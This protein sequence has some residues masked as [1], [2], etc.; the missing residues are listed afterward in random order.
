MPTTLVTLLIGALTAQPSVQQ[1]PAGSI[2]GTVVD[3]VAGTSLPGVVIALQGSRR[4]VV[5]DREGA[6]V[7]EAV[8]PGRHTLYVSLVGYALARPG[9]DVHAGLVSHVTVPLAPGTGAYTETVTVV[10]DAVR[11]SAPSV[12]AAQVLTSGELLE[13]RGVL[14]DDPLRAVQ[15]LPS[16][17]TGDDFRSEFSV[18]GSDFSHLGL[19]ID[20]IPVPW[21]V[22]TVADR[23]AEG[24]ISMVNGTVLDSVSLLA[25]TY[26]QDRPGRTGAWVDLTIREG[27][28]A[29]TGF[30]GSLSASAASFLVEGPLGPRGSWLISTRQSYLQWLLDRFEHEGQ[31][32]FGFTDLQAKFV[33]DAT[34]RNQLQLT[35]VGGH[36]RLSH[37]QGSVYENSI[38]GARARTGLAALAWR[39]AFAPT[40]VVTQRIAAGV[41]DFRTDG[42]IGFPLADGYASRLAY[43]AVADWTAG[44]A[45]ALQFGAY[46]QRHRADEAYVRFQQ[47]RRSPLLPWTDRVPSLERVVGDGWLATGHARVNWDTARWSIDAGLMAEPSSLAHEVP[48]SP[49]MLA[50]VPLRAGWSLRGGFNR[51]AQTPT[52]EQVVGTFKGDDVGP[53]RA[54]Q[55][56][57]ALEQRLGSSTR[58]QVTAYH[59][60][61]ADMLRLEESE[62]YLLN[63]EIERPSLTPYWANALVGTSRGIELLLQRRSPAGLSGW[64]GY[65]Y[66]RT[67]YTDRLRGEHF[68]GDYDQRHTLNVFALQRLSPRTSVSAK[69]RVASSFPIPGYYERRDGGIWVAAERNLER[70]PVYARLD[71]R[72]NHAFH[73]DQRRLTLFVEIVNLLDRENFAVDRPYVNDDGRVVKVMHSLFPFLPSAGFMVDF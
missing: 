3:A 62:T 59:R 11:G 33:V 15:A 14:T 39:S 36:A 30:H 43:R 50:R 16:V 23:E 58:W 24:S 13:L 54:R 52:L 20:G 37:E 5:S 56:D 55:L 10:S 19:S 34:P 61:E 65:A 4:E 40:V 73:F 31:T 38:N 7:F 64:V 57:L 67:E 27:S 26:P 8:P 70:L 2:R 29:T 71:V 48:W 21:P 9:V 45:L 25:G 6:F 53:E 12:P 1:P 47:V 42:I 49:W 35:L 66:G 17:A 28:R 22:H 68:P 44:S 46:A 51:T 72:A 18:R 60:R 32:A 41:N 63:G 69:L